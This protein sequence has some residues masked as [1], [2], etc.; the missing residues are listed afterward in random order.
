M[1]DTTRLLR[2]LVALPSINPMGRDLTG[3][4]I[5]EH[6]VTDWLETFFRDLGVS[7]ERQAIAP[8]R[9]NIIAVYEPPGARSTL[10]FEV[11]QDTVPTYHMTIPPFGAHVENG[12]LCGRGAG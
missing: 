6:Q 1:F 8:L 3:P 7:W 9:D 12:R 4:E 10:I 11:H 2:D 5:Y